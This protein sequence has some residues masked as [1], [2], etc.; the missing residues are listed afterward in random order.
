[1]P[2]PERWKIDGRV[3]AGPDDRT[4]SERET[5][6]ERTPAGATIIGPRVLQRRV[7]ADVQ[8]ILDA[9]ARRLL[10]ERL[11]DSS[12]SESD[13]P[14]REPRS[15][16]RERVVRAVERALREAFAHSSPT[17]PAGWREDA[18]AIADAALSAVRSV[19]PL[20]TRAEF[21][22]ILR[23]SEDTVDEMRIRGMPCNRW[24]ARLVRVRPSEALAWLEAQDAS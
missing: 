21:A 17:T 16:D 23:V 3:V 14:N 10:A 19:E 5:V 1:M 18:E 22:E 20:T 15:T 11:G 8:R 4:P 2:T 6:T 7:Y 9:A 24:G 12:A 13:M